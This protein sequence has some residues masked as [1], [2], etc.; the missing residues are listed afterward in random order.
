MDT[1]TFQAKNRAETDRRPLRV[2]H[3]TLS[4]LVIARHSLDNGLVLCAHLTH[5][6]SGVRDYV[7]R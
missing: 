7:T 1:R 4:T 6:A 5:G 2:F 3:T